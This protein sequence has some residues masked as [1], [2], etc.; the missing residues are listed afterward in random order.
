MSVNRWRLGRTL[1]ELRRR[2][3]Y[4]VLGGYAIAAWLTIQ[5]ADVVLPALMAPPWVLSVLVFMALLGLPVAAILAWVYDITPA[6]VVRTASTPQPDLT[7]ATFRWNWRWLDFLIIACL[8]AI[9]LFVL[10]KDPEPSVDLEPQRSIAVLPFTDLSPDQDTAY[11]GDGMAEAILDSLA[12][13]PGIEIA[14]RTSSFSSRGSE[15]G[16]PELADRLGVGSL[17]EGSIRKSGNRIRISARLVDGETGR[18]LWS[19]TYD[20]VLDDVFAVQDSISRAIVDVLRLRLL[21]GGEVMVKPATT[22]PQAYDAY[23]RGRSSLRREGTLENLEQSIEHFERALEQDTGFVLARAGLC[24]AHWQKYENTREPRHFERAL[25]TCEQARLQDPDRAETQIALGNMYRGTG[26]PEEAR[27]AFEQALRLDPGN[28][29][30]H[31]GISRVLEDIGDFEAAERHL[32]K[33]ISLDPA[34]WRNYSYLGGLLFAIG[35]YPGAAEQF[36]QAIRLEPDS[37]RSY[38]NLGGTL[39]LMGE[40]DRAAEA[41]RESIQRSPTAGGFS[42]AGIG[43]FNARRFAEAE[44]MFRVAAEYNPADFR[45][46]GFVADAVDMQADRQGE[47]EPYYQ[48]AVKLARERL[49]IN[50]A[51]HECRSSLAVYLARLGLGEAARQELAQL[52][53][54]EFPVAPIVRNMAQAHLILGDREQAFAR[55]EQAVAAGYPTVILAA[56]PWLDGLRDEPEVSALLG[57]SAYP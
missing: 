15:E 34:Y 52:A 12:R 26:Q 23:L 33:A 39:L 4:R 31:V 28:G 32:R 43:Y 1:V 22:N 51:D 9:L 24:T 47:A 57:R 54:V 45:F 40:F 29:E 5:I 30:A 53:L 27:G 10:V 38:A 21:G 56:E 17:L 18:Q 8:L 37:P 44:V 19:D 41:F 42:N 7:A 46:L 35:D 36:E 11:F 3:V 6:G 20:G 2:H 48:R 50:P 13:V 49:A 16:I 14:A 55:L 25:A